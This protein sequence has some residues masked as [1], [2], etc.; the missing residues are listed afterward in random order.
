MYKN[1][2]TDPRS[3]RIWNEEMSKRYDPDAFHNHKNPLIRWLE[4]ERVKWVCKLLMP[5]HGHRIL[6]VGCGA[7]KILFAPFFFVITLLRELR[8]SRIHFYPYTG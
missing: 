2:W 4:K 3:F 5:A 7:G 1:I 6:D 8:A